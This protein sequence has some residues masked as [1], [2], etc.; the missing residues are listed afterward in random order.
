MAADPSAHTWEAFIGTEQF[1]PHVCG[2][3]LGVGI[4]TWRLPTGSERSNARAIRRGGP[5]DSVV[6]HDET[7]RRVILTDHTSLYGGF[8]KERLETP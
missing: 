6:L 2:P 8:R 7:R 5:I 3:N 4:T 1:V